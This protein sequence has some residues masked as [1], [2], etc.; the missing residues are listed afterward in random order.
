MTFSVVKQVSSRIINIE[1]NKSAPSKLSISY[2]TAVTKSSSGKTFEN[3]SIAIYS[4]LNSPVGRTPLFTQHNVISSHEGSVELDVAGCNFLSGE[5]TIALCVGST[6]E[7]TICSYSHLNHGA[8]IAPMCCT[9]SLV[10]Q[11]VQTQT[12]FKLKV[13]YSLLEGMDPKANGDTLCLYDITGNEFKSAGFYRIEETQY[14]GYC[15]FEID[16]LYAGEQLTLGY[17]LGNILGACAAHETV[18]ID[19]LN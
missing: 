9:I 13:K 2:D 5:Y 12:G 15:E 16:S 1:I 3:N 17:Y 8:V 7:R 4:G 6:P 14:A 19:S 10:E 18:I 11:I